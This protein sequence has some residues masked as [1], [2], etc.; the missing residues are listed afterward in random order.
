MFKARVGFEAM[1]MGSTTSE[2]QMKRRRSAL[3]MSVSEWSASGII[4]P[5]LTNKKPF[6]CGKVFLCLKPL[7]QNLPFLKGD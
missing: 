1:E 7:I 3:P 6:L 4:P 2:R 5:K